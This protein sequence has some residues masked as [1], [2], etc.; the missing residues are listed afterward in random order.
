MDDLGDTW[1]EEAGDEKPLGDPKTR[2]KF[3]G[4]VSNKPSH[5]KPNEKRGETKG[6]VQGMSS[7]KRKMKKKDLEMNIAK[8][9][10]L[11]NKKR[12]IKQHHTVSAIKRG[13][14]EDFVNSLNNHYKGKLSSVEMD[15]I[16][17]P[18]SAF[19]PYKSTTSLPCYLSKVCPKLMDTCRDH[20]I[21]SEPLVLIVCSSALRCLDVI[22]N[23]GAFKER[24]KITKLFAKH[25]KM[26]EQQKF[27][28]SHTVHVGVGTPARITA[29]MVKGFLKTSSLQYVVID[30]NWQDQKLRRLVDIPELKVELFELFRSFV[31]PLV[32]T[33]STCIAL[34]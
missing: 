12:K 4:T 10:K 18:E 25:I 11:P 26:E 8:E 34:F 32:H 15:E 20:T 9:E 1:W 7:T 31:I 27:L 6:D 14:A 33:N 19:A 22:R 21:K 29:L 2:A 23:L 28:S 17:L 5:T 13:K 3:C 24:C 16:H 30:W